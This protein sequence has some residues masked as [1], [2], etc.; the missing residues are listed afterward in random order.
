MVANLLIRY[1]V[2]HDCPVWF[3]LG[4]VTDEPLAPTPFT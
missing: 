4:Q 3:W 1:A 2:T